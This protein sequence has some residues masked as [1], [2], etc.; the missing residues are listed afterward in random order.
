M[1]RRP[2]ESN[3]EGQPELNTPIL[4]CY[5]YFATG[6]EPSPNLKY[7]QQTQTEIRRQRIPDEQKWPRTVSVEK[8]AIIK[9]F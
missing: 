2:R 1:A 6:F 9:L 4:I 8:E 7:F 3:I 5:F